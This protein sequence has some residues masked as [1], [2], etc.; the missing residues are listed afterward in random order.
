MYENNRETVEGI[1]PEQKGALRLI[2]ACVLNL[3]SAHEK[4]LKLK[5]KRTD[6]WLAFQVFRAAYIRT[7]FIRNS[8]IVS[9]FCELF[10]YNYDK[11]RSGLLN[12]NNPR[13]NWD[14]TMLANK[15]CLLGEEV[16]T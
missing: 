14:A 12:R 3:V 11:V 16:I 2:K 10:G 4:F 7:A 6:S 1:T 15:C 8:R 9:D 13:K 5:S